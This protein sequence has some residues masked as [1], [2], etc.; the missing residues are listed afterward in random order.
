MSA[1][2]CI[3]GDRTFFAAASKSKLRP[4]HVP[5]PQIRLY[6]T[7]TTWSPGPAVA[8]A[9]ADIEAAAKAAIAIKA[10]TNSFIVISS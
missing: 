1:A 5:G 6:L 4:T 8:G 7:D 9:G 2:G 3:A 10:V